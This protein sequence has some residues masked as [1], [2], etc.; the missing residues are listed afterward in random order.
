MAVTIPSPPTVL[1][2]LLFP[3][4][5]RNSRT[6]PRI[7]SIRCYSSPLS[8]MDEHQKRVVVC[9]G[10]IIG[11]CTA[12]FLSKKGAAVT[13]VEKSSV[14]CAASGKAGG[15]L[16]LDWCDGGPISSLARASFNLHRS[17][18]E[19]LNG[20]ESYGYR[21]LN[22]LSLTVTESQAQKQTSTS[23]DENL[24]S[25]INGPARGPRT[26]GSPETTA[27]VHPQLFT[28]T[29]LSKA[30]ESYG[31]EV[32]TGKVEKVGVEGERVDSVVLEGGQVINSDAVVL[33]LG[34]W[35]GKFEMLSSLFRVYGLKAHSIILEPKELGAITP[36]AL[37]LSY[38]P[39]QG[40]RP[41]NPEVYPRPT[42]E[43]YLCGMSSEVE[44]PDDPEEIVG[45]PESIRVLKRVA[46]TVS[47]HLAE[48]E[49]RVKAEQACFL[50]CTDDGIPVIGEIPGVLGCYVAT[51][52]SCWGILNGPATGAAMAE[53]VVDGK[54]SIVDLS[55]F[56]PSRFV[57]LGK[58]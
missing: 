37:F 40:G 50:P 47:S 6:I 41:M 54:C 10:G 3:H 49:A 17:L 9:G 13:L 18:A 1:L 43:V 56:S 25:W 55:K 11:V 22:T 35:S 30:M 48:G 36:H 32:V 16:A 28:R 45:D 27:Q 38:Y 20:Y 53:L 29:L 14:A 15:F 57:R 23:R 19:E 21:T 52:H 31:V 12:Y 24:P 46:T 26:I 33:T 34:P 5:S 2:S 44:V 8:S 4:Q 39:A 42:G 51:G 7:S 58:R